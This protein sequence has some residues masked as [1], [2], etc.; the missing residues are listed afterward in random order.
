MCRQLT[1][2][3]HLLMLQGCQ[4]ALVA[5]RVDVAYEPAARIHWSQRVSQRAAIQLCARLHGEI[6][7]PSCWKV[8][9]C[10]EWHWRLRKEPS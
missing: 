4:Q 10:S 2:H 7:T 1:N 9:C 6:H 8:S 3:S 5:C